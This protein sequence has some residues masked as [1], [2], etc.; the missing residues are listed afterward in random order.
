MK[1]RLKKKWMNRP[2]GHIEDL[3]D[4]FARTLIDR[5]TAECVDELYVGASKKQQ[6]RQRKS[7]VTK[8]P[9]KMMTESPVQT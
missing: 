3:N 1:V 4:A 2:K 9:N 6:T 8:A 7:K 5:G